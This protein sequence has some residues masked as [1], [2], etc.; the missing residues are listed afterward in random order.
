MY[1]T[2]CTVSILNIVEDSPEWIIPTFARLGGD[3]HYPTLGGGYA[4]LLVG[5]M[6]GW[7][8]VM[9]TAKEENLNQSAIA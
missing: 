6:D 3:A 7:M 2:S 1:L 9:G 5:R 4:P 8:V